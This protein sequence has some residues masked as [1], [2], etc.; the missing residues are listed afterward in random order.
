MS[1]LKNG[2]MYPLEDVEV[3]DYGEKRR[4]LLVFPKDEEREIILSRIQEN[5]KQE[6]LEG[7]IWTTPGLPLLI[8][9]TLGLVI[10]LVYGDIVWIL[11][12]SLLG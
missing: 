1:K 2:H 12:S 8:F 11:L 10:S 6:N 5:I 3:N 9:I 4:K 7:E